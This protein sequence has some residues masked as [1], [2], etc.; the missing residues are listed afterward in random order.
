MNETKDPRAPRS[1]EGFFVS[2]KSRI[3]LQETVSP[4]N[5]DAK[6]DRVVLAWSVRWILN[7]KPTETT[8]RGEMSCILSVKTLVAQ[9]KN[10][11]LYRQQMLALLRYPKP[12]RDQLAIELPSLMG[13]RASEVGTW[14]AEYIDFAMGDTL[15]L[16]AKKK[17]LFTVPLNTTA[18]K[19]AEEVLNGRSNGY[20]LRSR[21]NAQPDPNRPLSPTAI[22][23]IWQKWTRLAGLPNARDISP[24]VGRRFFAAEWYHYRKLSLVTLQRIMRHANPL[25]TLR[26]V[27]SLV[28]YEDVKR[29]YDEFQLE[30]TKEIAP[31]QT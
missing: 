16:D 25:T 30:L 22:W 20:V 15:V 28:F 2:L 7:H 10:F 18:A 19:H 13:F 3:P 31:W 17:A 26:Y 6:R 1:I 5:M 21:S 24:V 4:V 23:Y 11:T 29:D 9:G 12:V 8:K 27:Q 14:K